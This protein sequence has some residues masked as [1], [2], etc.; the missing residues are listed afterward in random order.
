MTD[1]RHLRPVRDGDAAD[2]AIERAAYEIRRVIAGQDIAPRAH[3]RRPARAR[4]PP[5][6]GRPRPREDADDQDDRRRPRRHLPARPVHARPRALGP[7]R[8]ARLPA[9]PHRVRHRARPRLLQLPARGRDQPRAGQGAVGAA[10]GDA[11]A[12]TSRS[13]SRRCRCRRR[14]SSWR[15]RTR[16][17]PRAPTR[18]PRRSSTAS[19]SRCSSTTPTPRTSSSSSTAR[20]PAPSRSSRRSRS[21]ELARAPGS[22]SPRLRRPG[23]RPVRAAARRGD[24]GSRARRAWRS[25]HAYV[26]YGVSPRGPIN[27]ALAAR[28]LALL[29]GRRYVVANDMRELAKDVFRHRLV[30]S[31]EALADDVYARR[32]ARPRA[33]GRAVAR[34]GLRPRRRWRRER[35]PAHPPRADAR[36]ARA[37]ARCA[38]GTSAS[39]T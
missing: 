27:L 2:R 4:A 12:D 35:D 34:S 29:R 24:A 38:T 32:R 26:E 6:R 3:V 10:R 13:A 19:C 23:A 18:C 8:H 11:G 14:S 21:S 16:S 36:L 25:S 5:H 37:R 30:L 39:S 22:C 17:S 7:R 28:A 33:R 1:P 20:S 9:R 15:R 31:Y